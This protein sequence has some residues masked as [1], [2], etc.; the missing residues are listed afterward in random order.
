MKECGSIVNYHFD[1]NLIFSKFFDK[2]SGGAER[3]TK[4]F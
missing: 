3:R 1:V 2:R 4:Q